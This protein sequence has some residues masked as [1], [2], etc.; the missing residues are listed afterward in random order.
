MLGIGLLM[1][2]VGFGLILAQ[3]NSTMVGIIMIVLGALFTVE[4][5]QKRGVARPAN[6]RW[7]VEV[8]PPDEEDPNRFQRMQ[9]GRG[10]A[11][12]NRANAE[13]KRLSAAERRAAP[14][15]TREYEEDEPYRQRGA[16]L[17][18]LPRLAERTG[19]RQPRTVLR[20]E[21][22]DEETS[23]LLGSEPS[24][25]VR[26]PYRRE[27]RNSSEA[28]DQSARPSNPYGPGSPKKYRRG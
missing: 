1:F 9:T 19:Q 21:E 2:L 8:L 16:G 15:Q 13:P 10:P 20:D 26:F 5:S 22:N 24:A 27:P 11:R 6:S 17:G 4:G 12:L 3:S 23:R 14:L 25:R 18:T 28:A 7:K